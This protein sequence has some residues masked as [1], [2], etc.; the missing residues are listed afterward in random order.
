[1]ARIKAVLNER[2]L[3]YNG[4]VKILEKQ[5]DEIE[6]RKVLE[7]QTNQFKQERAYSLRRAAYQKAKR[8]STSMKKPISGDIDA[9]VERSGDLAPEP[10]EVRG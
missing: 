4:A 8:A 6:T 10:S 7:H 3:A 1:M 9:M 5:Q 2:R